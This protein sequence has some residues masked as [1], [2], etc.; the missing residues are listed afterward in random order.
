[1]L[2]IGAPAAGTN[3]IVPVTTAILTRLI[4]TYGEPAVAAY[5]AGTRIESLAVLVFFALASGLSPLVGQNWGADRRDRTHRA[6]VLSERVAIGWGLFTWALFALGADWLAGVFVEG[7][8]A[9]D[10]LALFLIVVPVGYAAQ[11]VFLVGNATL[12]AI[13][14]PVH[15][16]S[17]SLLRTLVLTAPLAWLASYWF[18]LA[19]IFGSIAVA[20]LVVGCAAALTAH[21]LID[22]APTGG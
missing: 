7:P 6:L 22:S 11:G 20:N 19:G 10:K 2:R 14:R 16:A 4:S 1:L 3:V 21:H 5:G 8:E 17:L 12:N 9:A 18:D 15:A 13:D